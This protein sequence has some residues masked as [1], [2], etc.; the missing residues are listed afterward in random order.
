MWN[1]FKKEKPVEQ[2]RSTVPF[3]QN[4]QGYSQ[5]YYPAGYYMG[6]MAIPGVARAVQIIAD[7]IGSLPW[8]AYTTHGKARAEKIFPRPPLLEQ[9]S[10]PET[11]ANTFS[12]WATDY[13]M[14]GNAFGI[15]SSWDANG[16]PTSVVPVPVCSV[17]IRRVLKPGESWLPVG[18]IEYK[19][20]SETYSSVEVIH[21]KGECRPGDVRGYGILELQMST[22]N[23]AHAQNTQAGSLSTAGVPTGV[24][25]NSNPDLTPAQAQA[26]KA[27]WLESQATR[28][29]A[30]LNAQTEFKA[31]AWNPEELQLIEAR[32]FMLTDIANMFGVPAWFLNA[33]T[34]SG[35]YSNIEQEAINLVKFGKL[36]GMIA[37]FEQALSLLFPRGTTVS[38]DLDALYRPDK[39][40]R[41]QTYEIGIRA[42]FIDADYVAEVEGLP[43]PKPLNLAPP[44]R[45]IE[46][47]DKDAT[48]NTQDDTGDKANS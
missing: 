17:G 3:W 39:M 33:E 21:I 24:L 10:P 40:A 25:T 14:N 12:A 11:R 29:V 7:V 1:P 36:Q 19:V 47:G 41:Y 27:S 45:Q 18:A 35:T 5:G 34:S 4:I 46:G 23:L 20:G 26:L 13:V 43:K 44:P 16:Y 15:I 28:T 38:I 8:D 2:T 22:L 9:P 48:N 37:R 31:L 42:G 6:A 30:V 32:K